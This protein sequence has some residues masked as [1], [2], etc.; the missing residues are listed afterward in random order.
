MDIATIAVIAAV[1]HPAVRF[2]RPLGIPLL[3]YIGLRS[4]SIYL[5]HWP[6]FALTRPGGTS[7]AGPVVVFVLRV[8][9][10]VRAGRSLLP[11]GRGTD[12]QRRHRALDG[13]LAAQP[14]C[15]AG[16]EDPAGPRSSACVGAGSRSTSSP[17][18]SSPPSRRRTTS[19]QSLQAG[20]AAHRRPD[21]HRTGPGAAPSPAPSTG[22]P[23]DRSRRLRRAA[24]ARAPSRPG[25]VAGT[26]PA[27]ETTTTVVLPPIPV[28]AIGDSVML[29]AAPKL[30]EALGADTY[31]DA[32]VGRQYKRGRADP[33]GAGD[34]GRLGRAVVLHL[35]NNGPMSRGDVPLR[36]GR[37]RPTCPWSWWSTSGSPS[38][39]SRR[40]PGAGR[41]GAHLPERPPARLV[42]RER[43]ARRL[44][45]QRQDPPEPGRGGRLRAS[46]VPSA[47]GAHH[48]RRTTSTTAGAHRPRR[49][50][51]RRRSTAD[52]RHRRPTAATVRGRAT[53]Q[54]DGPRS[55]R[56]RSPPC[57]NPFAS[58]S[59]EPP[60][61]SATASCSASPPAP[62]SAPT[63]R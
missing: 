31:V 17:A 37:A 62:C 38:R 11:P 49:R 41:A 16:P 55:V 25:G 30:L 36:D 35:G 24:V 32:V 43:D 59:P 63:S 29:G 18:P 61:R 47:V 48:R 6:V 2:G 27:V 54:R 39:G 57:P 13:G 23:R 46:S 1:A 53:A 50:D 45:L 15:G 9:D 56:L 40:Q 19:R 20:Q 7:D 44:V 42:G 52:P 58:P 10:H 22:A 34:Q 51:D 14:G 3:V 12:P 60:A 8:V 28:I 4:Y 26:L 21:D 5:W 33:P